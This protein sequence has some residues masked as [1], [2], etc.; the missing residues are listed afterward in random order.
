MYNIHS[1][2]ENIFDYVKTLIKDPV[3]LYFYPFGSIKFDNIETL[4][5]NGDG[6]SPIIVCYDQEPITKEVDTLLQQIRESW[7]AHRFILLLNTESNS[8]I[9]NT[10]AD[11]WYLKDCY[12]FFHIFA[13]ADWFRGYQYCTELLPPAQRK[14]KKK[15]ITFNRITGNSRAYRSFFVSELQKHK[16]I[17]HGHVSYSDVCPEHGHYEE[18]I[19][20]TIIKHNVDTEYVLKARHHLSQIDFPLRIDFKDAAFIDNGSQTLNAIPEMMESFLHVVTETCFWEIKDHLTEKIFKPIVA[21]QPFIL[22]GCANN[23]AYLKSYGFKTFDAWWDEGY[24]QIE[25]PLKRIQ[26]VV[27]IVNDICN[28]STQELEHLL[29]DMSETLNYN[30]N[31]FYSRNFVNDAWEEV[32]MSMH[33]QVVQLPSRTWSETLLQN[34]A[35]N[36]YHNTPN[37]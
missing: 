36:S 28:M 5:C 23:L 26:A 37:V 17:E 10:L 14:I 22:L 24:D 9:K 27:K 34:C 31:L 8:Q 15:Y 18:N 30:Y 13:A 6:T 11:R 21:R 32:K 33:Q 25:D 16:L 7:G 2:Y 20:E 1:H 3:L 4:H 35:T 19:L 29:V 12:Y